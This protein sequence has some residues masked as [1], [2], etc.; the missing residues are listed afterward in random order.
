MRALPTGSLVFLALVMSGCGPTADVRRTPAADTDRAAP[1]PE[2][3]S[4]SPA[5]GSRDDRGARPL[6]DR[7]PYV[8]P[9]TE[10][11]LP[12]PRPAGVRHVLYLNV[13]RDHATSGV[14]YPTVYLS[15][16]TTRSPSRATSSST[17]STAATSRR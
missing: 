14:R 15:I 16:P 10:M 11:R 8:L 7:A 2:R 5:G 4:A 9:H 12:P 1:G 13:P 17:S 3:P 6:E